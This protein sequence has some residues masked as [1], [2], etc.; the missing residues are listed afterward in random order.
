MAKQ[1]YPEA[2]IHSEDLQEIITKPPS[3][4][5][6]RGISFVLLTVL[7]IIGLSVF[8]RYPEMVQVSMKFNTSNAP[9][10]LVSKV[11]GNL[12]KILA[13]EGQWVE[14][15]TDIAYVESIA[16]HRQAIDILSRLKEIRNNGTTM[17]D[18]TDL[19]APTELDLGEL[20]GSYQNFYT[21]YLNYK[22]VNRE[23]ILQKRKH[24]IQ[25]EVQY[26][27]D[28]NA[29]TEEIYKLQ[30]D[31]LA[32]AEAEYEKYRLLAEKRII[33]PLELQRK[34]A[35]LLA[36][37]QVIPQMENTLISNR[38][39]LSAKDKELS[40]IDNQIIEEEKKFYQSLNTFISDAENWKKQYV[41]TT[42]SAGYLV[43]GDF[44]QE[45]Q[46]HKTG[47]IL[48]YINAGK[49]DYYGE[50]LIPQAA[51][52]RVKKEQKVMIR[53]RSYPYQEYGYLKG[54]VD[55]ISDIPVRDSLFFSRV[56]LVRTAADS[57][58]KLKPG[59]LADAEI[60]TEDQSIFRRIWLNLTK[61]LKY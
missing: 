41:I 24:F 13:R 32:L 56:A 16:E 46:L 48:F 34:K 50:V 5:M 51:S 42:P 54:K 49:N 6:K 22:A 15:N 55:Y 12:V 37:R 26:V 61:S 52:S 21:A 39:A 18:L 3:W 7:L 4:L 14:K 20:Q 43:Y 17:Q 30:K 9:K 33:S 10:A 59:I 11:N 44:L 1:N 35:V 40:E 28:Q 29:R 23:G 31:E 57:V 27:N 25:N 45:N 53:V 36:K 2:D 8:I 60:I 19:V 38:S 47:D 58:I